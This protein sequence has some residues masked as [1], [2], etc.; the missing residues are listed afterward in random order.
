MSDAS[1]R[2]VSRNSLDDDTAL[3]RLRA[4]YAAERTIGSLDQLASL[5]GYASKSSAGRKVDAFIDLG[6]IERSSDNLL[7]PG[8]FFFGADDHGESQP[9]PADALGQAEKAWAGG[10]STDLTK[11]YSVIVRLRQLV[12]LIEK[13]LAKTAASEGLT[14]GEVLV[15]DTLFRAG[16]PYS[17]SPSELREHFLISLAGIAK[18]VERLVEL[19]LVERAINSADRRATLLRLTEKGRE[20]LVR[21]TEFDQKSP[22]VTWPLTL[23]SRQYDNFTQ[24]LQRALKFLEDDDVDRVDLG[25]NDRS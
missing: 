2:S 9:L 14:A 16:E 19:R 21:L 7:R 24:V 23:S 20:T 18:R 4:H 11:A 5:W 22:Y 25:K 1:T 12:R 10:Y 17:L 6:V 13:G 3:L 15:L 8:P